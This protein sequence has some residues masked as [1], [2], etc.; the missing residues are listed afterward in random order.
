LIGYW[1]NFDNGSGNIKLR[2]VSPNWDWINVSFAEPTS[3]TSGDM[4][5][6]PYNATVDEFKADIAFLKSQ[7]KKVL[8][9]I[10]GANGQVQLNSAGAASTF[11]S[12]MTNIINTYGF[13]GFDIDFE[14]HSLVLNAGDSNVFSPTTPLIVNTINAIRNTRNGANG[15]MLTFAPETFFVQLGHSFY[16]GTCSGCDTRAGA[17]LPV[18]YALRNELSMLYVQNYNSGPITGLDGQYHTMGGADFHVAML[19]MLLTGFTV[20]GTGQTF[21]ALPANKVALGVPANVNAGGGYT[22]EAEVQAAVGYLAGVRGAPSGYTKRSGNSRELSIMSW[23]INW[24]QFN[25]F[26]FSNSHRAYLNSL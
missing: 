19:D 25:N 23:S 3:A 22:S 12:T 6:T 1:H 20:S 26:Q 2:N 16:G 17:Y 15:K 5:F 10:G 11:T 13:D 21:P 24:D 14:G 9:S 4:R 7:G 18:L 8:I